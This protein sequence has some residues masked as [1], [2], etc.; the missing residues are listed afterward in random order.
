MQPTARTLRHLVFTATLLGAL[1]AQADDLQTL[2]A[3]NARLRSRVE[4]LERENAELRGAARTAQPPIPERIVERDTEDG[5]TIWATEPARIDT[6]GGGRAAHRLWLERSPGSPDATLW[7]RGEFS[8]GIYRQVD[9]L[10]LRLDGAGHALP[11]AS[12]KATRI[13]AGMGG[14]RPQRRDHEFVSVTLTP[15][16]LAALGQAATMSGRLGR[17]SFTVPAEALASLRAL[18]RKTS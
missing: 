14:P 11:V 12:Y 5:R 18:A 9:R 17:M 2:E 10:E 1:S 6:T 13:T 7:I 8:G 16:V 4:Q 3:E 15:A